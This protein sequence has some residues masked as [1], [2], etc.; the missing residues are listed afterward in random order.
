ARAL[1]TVLVGAAR[2]RT[3]PGTPRSG[4]GPAV[5]EELAALRL[6]CPGDPEQREV[7]LDPLRSELDARR[8]V[9]L[10]R[11]LACGVGYG[12]PVGVTATGDSTALT[13]RWRI[14]WTPGVPAL[15]DLAGVR[16]VTLA[17]A[18]A[19]TLREAFRRESADGGA[20]C[21]LILDGL[22]A[23]AR[24]DLPDLVADR[25]ADATGA[26][27]DTATLAE[28]LDA[29]DLLEALRRRHVPGTT[30]KER[31]HAAELSGTLLEAAVRALPGL[32]GSDRPEDAAALV[33]L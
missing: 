18:A 26:L 15:L 28:L 9:A 32:A 33:A 25:L 24:C 16:G 21:A 17:Q 8:E 6:P 22:R 31:E 13:T 30:A 2:G 23:A 7:R 3:A 4:L 27:P 10:Q 19:G 1:D 14:S 20:T 12:E 5:E 29:L 11:L